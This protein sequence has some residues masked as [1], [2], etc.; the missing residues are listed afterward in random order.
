[1]VVLLDEGQCL[2]LDNPYELYEQAR[3][4]LGDAVSETDG[5]LVAQKDVPPGFVYAEVSGSG[6]Y[7]AISRENAFQY[8]PLC[9]QSSPSD[10]HLIQ[11][12]RA[13]PAYPTAVIVHGWNSAASNN[14][15]DTWQACMARAILDTVAQENVV[16]AQDLARDILADDVNI[17]F[18]DWGH[19][20]KTGLTW[21]SSYVGI[22]DEGEKLAQALLS[23][24]NQGAIPPG[25]WIHLIGHRHGGFVSAVCGQV[26]QDTVGDTAAVGQLTGLD[27]PAADPIAWLAKLGNP[28]WGRLFSVLPLGGFVPS[29]NQIAITP[30]VFGLITWHPLLGTRFRLWI[31]LTTTRA[32]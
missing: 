28:S 17:F 4:V 20:A 10:R 12:H 31:W 2:V 18:W 7:V 13:G 1:M 9:T 5:P 25:N 14:D 19:R 27:V 22:N 8:C 23:S 21:W 29:T 26:I 30:G 3:I 32:S 15:E 11:Y 16:Q 6:Q 24:Q